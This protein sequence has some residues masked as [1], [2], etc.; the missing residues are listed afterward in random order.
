[1][2][3]S[4]TAAAAAKTAAAKAAAAKAAQAQAA[5]Q[6]LPLAPG[7]PVEAGM[8][9]S[10][11]SL[12]GTK[13]QVNATNQSA[14]AT[15]GTVNQTVSNSNEYH[16]TYYSSNPY[17]YTGYGVGGGYGGIG[18][19]WLPPGYEYKYDARLGVTLLQRKG[20]LFGWLERLVSGY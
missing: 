1:M 4:V 7:Y 14:L 8:P 2:T 9:G 17:N 10:L 11:Q 16:N 6:T 13:P 20:G 3:T 15:N 19:G 18:G 5:A 12:D